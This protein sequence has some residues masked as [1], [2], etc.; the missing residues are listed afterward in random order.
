MRGFLAV[1][2]IA[3]GSA[4]PVSAETGASGSLDLATIAAT[5]HSTTASLLDS[6][7]V[8]QPAVWAVM[9]A[10]FGVAGMVQRG[11]RIEA[12]IA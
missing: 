5:I 8:P 3:L 6:R 7:A 4:L 11:R 10:G 9:F 12:E 2:V 1:A